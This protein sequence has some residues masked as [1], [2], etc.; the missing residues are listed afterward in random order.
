MSD[1]GVALAVLKV[2]G[3]EAII[4]AQ[5]ECGWRAKFTE[6]TT[7]S[8]V[9]DAVNEHH[10]RVL[11]AAV[12]VRARQLVELSVGEFGKVLPPQVT[13]DRFARWALTSLN[14]GLMSPDDR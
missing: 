10:G 14:K 2:P 13:P 11:M 4:L 12:P 8:A 6:V 5:C 3:E 1:H 7:F 9:A